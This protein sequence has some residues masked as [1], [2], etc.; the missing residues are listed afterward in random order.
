M[1]TGLRFTGNTGDIQHTLSL[2]VDR[3]WAKYWNNTHNSGKGTIIGNL[4]DGVAYTSAFSIPSLRPATLSWD[5][6]NTGVTIADS[7]KYNKW[8]FL[9]AA[10][11][12]QENFKNKANGKNFQN[13]DWLPTYGI[14]Y[15][16]NDNFS[17]YAGQTESLSRGAVVINGSH[18]YDNVGDTLAPSKSKQK[19]VGVKYQIG[20][21]LTTLSYFYINQQSL[22]DREVSDGLYHRAA[23]GREKFK[24]VEWTLNGKLAPKWTITGGLM[25]LDAKRTKTQGG[26]YDGKRVNGVAD[27]SGVLGL[28]YEPNDQLGIIGRAVWCDSA[29]IDNSHAPSGRTE[30]PSYTVFDLG[31]NYKT[32]FG[33]YPVTLEA[34]CYNVANKDYWMGR[35]SSTTFGL[36]MP[37]TFMLSAKFSF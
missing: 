32:H 34:M 22:I 9:V 13:D 27:W 37:R 29:Y 12:K 24:G 10:S 31:V 25:Y 17:V 1:Q 7:M 2:A 26:T 19:E 20:N 5:E 36:S 33:Q 35:G 14:T 16:A 28:V 18:Q 8:N 21:I 30:I 11:H 15:Q 3:S 4:Y 6:V 23:D